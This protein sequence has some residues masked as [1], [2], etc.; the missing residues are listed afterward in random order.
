L[1]LTGSDG[2]RR[3]FAFDAAG[4]IEWFEEEGDLSQAGSTTRVARRV[5]IA[6]TREFDGVSFPTRMLESIGGWPSEYTVTALSVNRGVSADDFRKPA[7]P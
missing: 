3:R 6:A 7:E 4:D 5:T 2:F 1:D